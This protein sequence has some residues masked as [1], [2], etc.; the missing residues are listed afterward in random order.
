MADLLLWMMNR[1]KCGIL[2]LGGR[3]KLSKNEII[4][5]NIKNIPIVST[6]NYLGITFN[7]TMTLKHRIN[8]INEKIKKYIKMTN[9]LK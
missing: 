8:T 3:E 1:K 9:M 7:K 6:Y 2:F 5:K 4:Q